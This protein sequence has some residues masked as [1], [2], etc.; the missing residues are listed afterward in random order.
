MAELDELT[1][2]ISALSKLA[3]RL[4]GDERDKII[5]KRNELDGKASEL[6]HKTLIDSGQE[7]DEAIIDLNKSTQAA[8]AAK[9]SINDKVKLIEKIAD[10]VAKTTKAIVSVSA[11]IAKL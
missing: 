7:L 9:D 4:N 5:E 8:Q 1:K 10:V 11:L 2:S 6:A 3:S